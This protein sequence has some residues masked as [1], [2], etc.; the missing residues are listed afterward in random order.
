MKKKEPSRKGCSVPIRLLRG[1][2]GRFRKPRKRRG[3][4]PF[5]LFGG[6]VGRRRDAPQNVREKTIWES[7]G[8]DP[9]G[10]KDPPLCKETT[11]KRRRGR[12]RFAAG[13]WGQDLTR[14]KKRAS[15]IRTRRKR[16]L[17]VRCARGRGRLEEEAVDKRRERLLP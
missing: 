16:D 3:D 13:S 9:E 1:G 5:L 11:K 12:G 10:E 6:E 2:I 14:K 7:C 17:L 15:E 8:R 4:K